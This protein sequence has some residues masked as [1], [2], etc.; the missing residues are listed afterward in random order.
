MSLR[1]I[2][3]SVIPSECQRK[4][5]KVF[6]FEVCTCTCFLGQID[7]NEYR[8]KSNIDTLTGGHSFQF[9]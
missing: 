7:P 2:G 4:C 1:L 6:T 8:Y 5:P 9:L 3:V